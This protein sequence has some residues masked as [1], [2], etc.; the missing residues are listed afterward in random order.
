MEIRSY[1][2]KSTQKAVLLFRLCPNIYLFSAK[3]HSINTIWRVKIVLVS[4][5]REFRVLKHE[6]TDTS[7]NSTITFYY[8][9]QR[10]HRNI[11]RYTILRNVLIDT[12]YA[13]KI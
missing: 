5:K 3:P 11:C 12:L 7:Q 6:L 10:A 2:T 8:M 13:N 9:F 4:K 1:N